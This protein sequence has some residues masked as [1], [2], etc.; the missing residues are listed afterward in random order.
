MTVTQH[1]TRDDDH[2]GLQTSPGHRLREARLVAKIGLDELAARLHLDNKLVEALENDQYADL[3]EPTFVRGYLRAY[4]RLLGLPPAPIIE[5]YDRHG[6]GAPQLI[7]DIASRPQA[8]SSDT[9]VRLVTFV[10]TA[11]LIALMTVWW[12]TQQNVISVPAEGV[13]ANADGA[14][15]APAGE[16]TMGAVVKPGEEPALTEPPSTAAPDA[17]EPE[18]ATPQLVFSEPTEP[19]MAP[20]AAEAVPS[21]TAEAVPPPDTVRPEEPDAPETVS[22]VEASPSPQPAALAPAGT[23]ESPSKDRLDIRFQ[24]DS[25]VEIYDRDETQLYFGL[26]KA[27]QGVSVAGGPPLRVLLGYARDVQIEYNGA[28]FDPVPYMR[29][30]VARFTLGA[31]SAQ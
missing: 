6:F 11:V 5:A 31:A 19:T 26:A 25:W 16:P 14:A 2:S 3:P 12:Q 20:P 17:T 10:V 29:E 21:P 22:S 24:H 9:F 18:G 4:A 28:F 23:G 8:Q 7:P 1:D 30:D 15:G 27:G 13:G